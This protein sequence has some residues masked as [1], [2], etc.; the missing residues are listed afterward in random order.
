MRFPLIEGSQKSILLIIT[1]LATDTTQLEAF[2]Q[3]LTRNNTF[4]KV[5]CP[6]SMCQKIPGIPYQSTIPIL[7]DQLEIGSQEWDSLKHQLIDN[8]FDTAIFLDDTIEFNL[9][10][11]VAQ[12]APTISLRFQAHSYP[13]FHNVVVNTRNIH[14]YFELFKRGK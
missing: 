11:M 7:N 9:N 3:R 13:G 6:Q 5:L 2:F 14:A 10:M 12:I 1:K 4:V 8:D